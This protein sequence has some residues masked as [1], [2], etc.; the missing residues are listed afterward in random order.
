MKSIHFSSDNYDANII[1][2]NIAYITATAEPKGYTLILINGK[3]INI[4]EDLYNEIKTY[5]LSE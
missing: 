1:I 3:S 5:L 2:D 4:D